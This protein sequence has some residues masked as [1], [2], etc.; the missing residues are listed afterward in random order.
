M[1]AILK[2]RLEQAKAA[3]RSRARALEAQARQLLAE[4]V[5]TGALKAL[6]DPRTRAVGRRA[7]QNR[8]AELVTTIFRLTPSSPRAKAARRM[9]HHVLAD[10]MA[11]KS[12]AEV[13]ARVRET[14]HPDPLTETL[15]KAVGAIRVE[16]PD[17]TG[18]VIVFLT[19]ANG[20]VIAHQVGQ[21]GIHASADAWLTWRDELA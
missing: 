13:A 7:E 5:R 14:I 15:A 11:S 2:A 9:F 17:E 21:A 20:N 19:S 10:E 18:G 8:I 12:S 1:L 16:G 3:R 6:D 4:N